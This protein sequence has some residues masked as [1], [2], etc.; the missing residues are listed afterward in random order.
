LEEVG[1]EVVV[2]DPGFAPMYATRSKKIKTDKRDARALADACR[3]GGYRKAHRCSDAQREVKAQ[4]TVREA[5]VRTRSRYISIVRSMVRQHGLRV[6]TGAA[7][8]FC[9]R[10]TKVALPAEV[11]QVVKPLVQSVLID[12]E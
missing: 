3:I 1:C 5:L 7:E 10:L 12:S 4:L 11:A 9:D 6:A 2:A 8:T